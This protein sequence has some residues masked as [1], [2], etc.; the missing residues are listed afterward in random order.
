[1]SYCCCAGLFAS[2]REAPTLRQF[3][4]RSLSISLR[5][6]KAIFYQTKLSG[7][8]IFASFTV[9]NVIARGGHPAATFL[10]KRKWPKTVAALGFHSSNTP[11]APEVRASLSLPRESDKERPGSPPGPR[12]KRQPSSGGC[13]PGPPAV[14]GGVR[15][16][17]GPRV[18]RILPKALGRGGG[19]SAQ[20]A[21]CSR[22]NLG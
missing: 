3:V 16:S 20:P 22:R 7:A 15:A 5:I 11:V 18:G 19:A 13:R 17:T 10:I 14:R 21:R 1:M 6:Q 12:A 4:R 9:A 8:L 2:V